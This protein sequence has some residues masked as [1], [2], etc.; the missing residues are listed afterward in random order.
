M[1]AN[2]PVQSSKP[3]V[4]VIFSTKPTMRPTLNIIAP[5]GGWNPAIHQK[6]KKAVGKTKY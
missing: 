3:Q 4:T 5:E 2:L 6:Q 1:S